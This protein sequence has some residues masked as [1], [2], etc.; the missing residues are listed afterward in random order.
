MA[1]NNQ[2]DEAISRLALLVAVIAEAAVSAI[3]RK[4]ANEII[5][6]AKNI[7]LEMGL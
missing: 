4:T 5:A 2:R 7:E 3:G 6:Q 1:S